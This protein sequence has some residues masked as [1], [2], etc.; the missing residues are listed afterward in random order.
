[1]TAEV[2]FGGHKQSG[3][4]RELGDEALSKSEDDTTRCVS[5]RRIRTAVELIPLFLRFFRE[6]HRV[7]VCHYQPG[8]FCSLSDYCYVFHECP[9]LIPPLV[10]Y[11]GFVPPSNMNMKYKRCIFAVDSSS[12]RLF[13]PSRG[14]REPAQEWRHLP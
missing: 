3:I 7:E 9:K 13:V 1:L 8:W 2:A 6:L 4:G 11:I 5:R 14:F 12:K 10:L